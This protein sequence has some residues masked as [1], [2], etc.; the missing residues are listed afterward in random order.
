MLNTK[1]VVRKI[2]GDGVSRN[3]MTNEEKLL[4]LLQLLKNLK[5]GSDAY[6]KVNQQIDIVMDR[7]E[8]ETRRGLLEEASDRHLHYRRIMPDRGNRN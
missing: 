8:P 2:L 3:N 7:M 4:T 1:N 6:N 5:K